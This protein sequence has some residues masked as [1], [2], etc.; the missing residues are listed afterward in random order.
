M[1]FVDLDGYVNAVVNEQ[2]VIT[3][4]KDEDVFDEELE[5]VTDI[6]IPYE[7]PAESDKTDPLVYHDPQ[8]KLSAIVKKDKPQYQMNGNPEPEENTS[9][10]TGSINNELQDKK[11]IDA[12]ANEVI[13]ETKTNAILYPLIRIDQYTLEDQN[14]KSFTLVLFEILLLT[15]SKEMP[16]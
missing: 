1:E 9:N 6:L 15:P 11:N 4:N 3:P 14:I 12:G 5:S 10:S 7:E 2:L 16:F 8:I 13:D